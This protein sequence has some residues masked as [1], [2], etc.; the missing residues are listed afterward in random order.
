VGGAG[1]GRDDGSCQCQLIAGLHTECATG[2]ISLAAP[3]I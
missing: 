2:G 1:G 3:K